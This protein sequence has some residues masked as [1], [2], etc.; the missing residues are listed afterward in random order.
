[1]EEREKIYPHTHSARNRDGREREDLPSYSLRKGQGWKKEGRSTSPHTHSARDRD[2]RERE[3]LPPLI[4]TPLGTGMEERRKFYTALPPHQSHMDG[5]GQ[6][7][8]VLPQR[9]ASG[10]VITVHMTKYF[11]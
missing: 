1:M 7:R 10:T 5:S 8:K 11:K 4:L 9:R 6:R 2:G 3:D